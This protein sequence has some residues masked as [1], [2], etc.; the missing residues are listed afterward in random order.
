M[1]GMFDLSYQVFCLRPHPTYGP[2]GASIF[3]EAPIA[4]SISLHI[5]VLLLSH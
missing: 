4:V 1:L 3:S 2:I 5:N